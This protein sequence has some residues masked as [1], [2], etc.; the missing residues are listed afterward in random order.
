[1]NLLSFAYYAA[2]VVAFFIVPAKLGASRERINLFLFAPPILFALVGLLSGTIVSPFT[3]P[4]S[5][6]VGG[7]LF[8]VSFLYLFPALFASAIG[9]EYCLRSCS[10]VPWKPVAASFLATVIASAPLGIPL[11]NL[12][13]LAFVEG[14]CALWLGYRHRGT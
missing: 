7:Y 12:F 11:Q 2:A 3:L 4:E 1:M 5:I 14:S 6:L 9:Y 8:I 13:M 10:T